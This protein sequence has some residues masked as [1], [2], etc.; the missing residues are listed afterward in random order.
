MVYWWLCRKGMMSQERNL[1]NVESKV[2][3]FNDNYELC[4]SKVMGYKVVDCRLWVV[5]AGGWMYRPQSS[6][7]TINYRRTR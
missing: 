3:R 2:Y 7:I 1:R 5:V 6:A 4:V